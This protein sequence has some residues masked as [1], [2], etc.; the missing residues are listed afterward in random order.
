MKHT[1][2]YQNTSPA[3]GDWCF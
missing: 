1:N 3:L 2:I